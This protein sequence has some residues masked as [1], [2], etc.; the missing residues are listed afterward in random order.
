MRKNETAAAA[1]RP[2]V[3][4]RRYHVWPRRLAAAVRRPAKLE[5]LAH[6]RAQFVACL[7]AVVVVDDEGIE[8]VGAEQGDADD[9]QAEGKC[10][11]AD[12]PAVGEPD[13]ADDGEGEGDDHPIVDR[14]QGAGG[15]PEGY[16]PD[17]PSSAVGAQQAA[18][19][20]QPDADEREEDVLR[21]CRLREHG[22]GGIDRGGECRP[23]R[24]LPRNGA[25][26]REQQVQQWKH[27]GDQQ[28]VE[29]QH[30]MVGEGGA[31]PSRDQRRDQQRVAP[32][33]ER[34]QFHLRADVADD[35]AGVSQ[36]AHLVGDDDRT[37]AYQR[38][39]DASREEDER[40][41]QQH[42]PHPLSRG[43]PPVIPLASA[44]HRDETL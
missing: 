16:G 22:Q 40:A 7:A 39:D 2:N 20:Q 24:D 8:I 5:E 38:Q 27:A 37:G 42:F 15:T 26:A 4:T 10:P 1:E 36:V 12:A 28:R 11:R 21:Q 43:D 19:G 29:D 23:D 6:P 30:Q 33:V 13:H 34:R 35:R 17:R 9:E 31:S 14:P 25:K 32:S 41:Q 44:P 18:E 3:A